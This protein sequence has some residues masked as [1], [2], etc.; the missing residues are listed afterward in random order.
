MKG[1]TMKKA[2]IA[3]GFLVILA[4]CNSS[5]ENLQRS[6]ASVI[7]G[8]VSPSRVMV[9]NIDRQLLIGDVTWQANVGGKLY[10]CSADDN[11]HHP[12]CVKR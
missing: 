12:Y 2:S 3:L 6:T 8:N 9:S 7:P 5:E 4:G 1:E 10:D 11:V